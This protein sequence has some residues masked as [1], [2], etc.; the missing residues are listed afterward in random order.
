MTPSKLKY[1]IECT[2]NNPHFFDRKTMKFWGDTMSNYG[3]RSTVV[4]AQFNEEGEYNPQG[5]KTEVWELYRKS[6]VKHGVN[7]SAYFRK[8]NYSRVHCINGE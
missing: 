6:P 1:Q 4:L 2:G 5:Y 8:S 3:V 7:K